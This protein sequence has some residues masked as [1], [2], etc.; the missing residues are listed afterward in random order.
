MSDRAAGSAVPRH[1][2]VLTAGLGTRLRPL[3]SVRAK[4]AV[5]VAGVPLVERI[6]RRLAAAGV[7]ELVL[8]LHHRPETVA[9]VLGDGTGLG[10]RV[11]YS[12]E[13]PHILGSA[14]GPARAL[15]IIGAPT[16]LIVNG[17][18]LTDVDLRALSDAHRASGAL[19]TLALVPN[20]EPRKYGGVRLDDKRR[21]TGF[22]AR[23]ADAV[24]SFHFVGVQIA[25]ATAFQNVQAGQAVNT[26][27]ALY[28]D[29]IAAAPGTIAGHVID[30]DCEF[31][32]IGTVADYWR[33]SWELAR[34][35]GTGT[36]LIGSRCR[37]D[38]AAALD[39]SI[40]WD[41]VT[42]GAGARLEECIVTDGVTV[43]PGAAHRRAVLINAGPGYSA[44]PFSPADPTDG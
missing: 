26:V 42:V 36:P 38:P 44:E 24:E 29:L 22:V 33:T 4:P 1:A 13:H 28:D 25:A 32:D 23:G 3:T 27:G 41:D 16:F 20:R 30:G 17:D 37:I 43:P 8:N 18:T 19:V 40:L 9:R 10:V 15:D 2:L 34:L 11:R 12:W 5:P 35:E 31:R 21:V 14:G 6:V 39:R 7:G